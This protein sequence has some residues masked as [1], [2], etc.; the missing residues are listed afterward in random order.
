MN[1]PTPAQAYWEQRAVLEKARPRLEQFMEAAGVLSILS[2][3]QWAQLFA[4]AVHF[5]PDL[6]IELGRF[7][8]NSTCVFTEA[9]H[10]LAPASCR[11]VSLCLADDWRRKTAPRLRPIV[12]DAWFAPLQAVE[13]N[14]LFF[15]FAAALAGA[16]RVLLFWDAH[17]YQI[18]ECVLG[19]VLPL[20][21]DRSHAVLMH[22]MS[23]SRY[24]DPEFRK[25]GGEGLWRGNNNGHT[26]LLL[27]NINTQVEQAVSVVDFTTRNGLTLQSADHTFHQEIG[28]DPQKVAEMRRLL[29]E[30]LFSLEGHWF[31][32]SLNEKP[33]PYTFPKFSPPAP[34]TL[35]R[36][37][38]AA[39]RLL[40]NRVPAELIP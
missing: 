30:K 13:G 12:G 3:H 2:A 7:T 20:L 29:G 21:A 6:I 24:I 36:R 11:V 22:D 38:K 17:G 1:V 19:S 28:S 8:G 4:Y 18:A 23:D 32:F 25:Y 31:Y 33:G 16:K 15:D 26:R 40:L 10:T 39:A 5:R 9:A 27:G 14:I 34:P 37:L 35:T